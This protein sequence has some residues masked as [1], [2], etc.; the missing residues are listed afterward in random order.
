MRL[1]IVLRLGEGVRRRRPV[2]AVM[3]S[4]SFVR[5]LSERERIGEMKKF[6]IAVMCVWALMGGAEIA[7]SDV[8]VFSGFPWKDV[9]IGYTISDPESFVGVRRH[10]SFTSL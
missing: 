1:A 3:D 9:A 4:V 10:I 5:W 7:V 8:Q 6:V 2:T